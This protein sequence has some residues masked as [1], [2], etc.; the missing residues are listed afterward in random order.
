L[1][2]V[3]AAVRNAAPASAGLSGW[4]LLAI[5]G[6]LLALPQRE[7]CTIDLIANLKH[8]G[9]GHSW[10]SSHQAQGGESGADMPGNPAP[11]YEVG[12]L[13]QDGGAAWPV[14]SFDGELRIQKQMPDKR[15]L[16]IFIGSG[17]H[18][19]GIA[20]D[21]LELLETDDVLS[22][23]AIPGCM[24]GVASPITGFARHQSVV[25]AV[26]NATSLHGYLACPGSRT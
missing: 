16:C 10:G 3:V 26:L 24:A 2:P 13:L 9:S 21:R 17:S 1:S 7:V 18:V 25:V 15:R 4:A 5:D 12:W 11:G 20:C 22:V 14:Y 6:L 8:L 19:T 23:D